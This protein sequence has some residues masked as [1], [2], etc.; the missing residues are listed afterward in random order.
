MIADVFSSFFLNIK[1]RFRIK[2][3]FELGHLNEMY[4]EKLYLN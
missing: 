2:N 4:R 3:V 1:D